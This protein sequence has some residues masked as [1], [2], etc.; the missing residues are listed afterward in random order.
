[1]EI[2]GSGHALMAERPDEVLDALKAFIGGQQA[3]DKR[4]AGAPGA[5]PITCA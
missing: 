3:A 2:P 5:G 1:V 4:S